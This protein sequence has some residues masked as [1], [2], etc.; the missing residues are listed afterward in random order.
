MRPSNR[1]DR[2]RSCDDRAMGADV[3]DGSDREALRALRAALDR[4]GFTAERVEERLGTGELSSRPADTATSPAPARRGRRVLD[5]RARVSPR[6]GGAGGPL[7]A[8]AGLPAE[9]LAALGLVSVDGGLAHGRG[10]G[11]SRTATTSSRPTAG[12]RAA[13]TS[14]T[15]TSRGSRRRQS[16]SR[17]S[18][19]GG[20]A[21]ARSTSAPAAGSR[22][23]SPRGTRSASSRRTSTRARSASRPSTPR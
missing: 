15:T 21:P 4:A 22:R 1:A 11:S 14:R 17:S 10:C 12:P 13:A 8:A 5:A 19:S 6:R 9:R 3:P 7:A 23:S 2:G 18:R 20:R 16:R